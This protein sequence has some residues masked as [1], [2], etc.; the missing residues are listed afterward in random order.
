MHASIYYI[1]PYLVHFGVNA[2]N[3]GHERVWR[4]RELKH[5]ICE[6]S[7]GVRARALARE[8]IE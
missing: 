2:P 5:P 8:R 6:V 4:R 1:L 3:E 7:V